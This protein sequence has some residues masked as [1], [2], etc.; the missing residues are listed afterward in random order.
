MKFETTIELE[1]LGRNLPLFIELIGEDQWYKRVDELD[2][3]QRASPFLG[4]IV[5]DYHWLE[6]AISHQYEVFKDKEKLDPSLIDERAKAA[7]CFALETVAVFNRLSDVG[8]HELKGRLRGCLK[9]EIGF[10]D[11]YL[12]LDTARRLM[13]Q[14][15]DVTF[16]DMEKSAQFDLEYCRGAFRAEVECKSISTDAGRQIHRKDFYRFMHEIGPAIV[17]HARKESA[18]I[19]KITLRRRLSPKCADQT[20]L[21]NAATLMLTDNAPKILKRSEFRI[22]RIS[23]SECFDGNSFENDSELYSAC[24]EIFGTNIHVSG[25]MS[26]SAGCLVVM[27]SD[28]QDDTSKPLLKAMQKAAKQLTGNHP[29]FIAVQFQEIEPRDLMLPQLRRRVGILSYALYDQYREKHL[30]AIFFCG[31]GGIVMD[32]DGVGS[33]AFSIPNP[34]PKFAINQA[35]REPFLGSVSDQKF[36]HMI[37][38]PLPASNI[39][40][41]PFQDL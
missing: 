40:Y 35:N 8:Q 27:K 19:L 28:R 38:S 17:E 3:Q 14:G 24:T 13:A 33:P 1:A 9:A 26:D 16:S 4:I 31:F 15:Y 2:T 30:N 32:N 37:G 10:A 21:T 36:A 11:L 12:E 41:L 25:T 34:G 5:S 18:E 23:F 20:A 6:M 29:A 39:S 22:E 7:L